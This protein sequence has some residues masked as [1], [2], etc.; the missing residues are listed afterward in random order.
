ML[1]HNK[2][3]KM[4]ENSSTSYKNKIHRVDSSSNKDSKTINFH[5]RK[6]LI[7]EKGLPENLGNS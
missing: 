5:A 4:E 7:S 3:V 6:V 2:W 1:D